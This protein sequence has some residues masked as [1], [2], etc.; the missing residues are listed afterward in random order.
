MSVAIACE[1]L[2]RTAC[3][4]AKVR[5]L[6]EYGWELS[7]HPEVYAAQDWARY[8]PPQRTR[9]T[10]RE[11][12]YL[13]DAQ[14]RHVAV[15]EDDL[16]GDEWVYDR[17]P[18]VARVDVTL[19]A[20][21]ILRPVGVVFLSFAPE[22]GRVEKLLWAPA[23]GHDDCRV[24]PK[25]PGAEF[26]AE[27]CWSATHPPSTRDPCAA[28]DWA[29]E[30]PVG[31]SKRRITCRGWVGHA[32]PHQAYET[33]GSSHSVRTWGTAFPGPRRHGALD[34]YGDGVAASRAV[35]THLIGLGRTGIRVLDDPA[36]A[37]AA[38]ARKLRAPWEVG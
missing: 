2:V 25:A 23:C 37:A 10:Y 22:G 34:V 17:W 13:G 20:T 21:S 16:T 6:L 24:A 26:M 32:G 33:H 29:T 35:S 9:T 4:R 27:A 28:W 7:M 11:V 38:N 15:T 36:A 30:Y 3:A 1:A 12:H 14:P 31:G 5:Q 18:G 19:V 8:I